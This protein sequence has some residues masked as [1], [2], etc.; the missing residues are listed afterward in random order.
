MWHYGSV[1]ILITLHLGVPNSMWYSRSTLF[2]MSSISYASFVL[3]WIRSTSSINIS[4]SPFS[5]VIPFSLYSSFSV[6]S[7]IRLQII[8]LIILPFVVCYLWCLFLSL[9]DV[10]SGSPIEA[11]LL[12]LCF[13]LPVF[14]CICIFDACCVSFL[15]VSF[16]LL[17]SCDFRLL[18][19]VFL[20]CC[21]LPWFHLSYTVRF[22]KNF[23]YSFLIYFFADWCLIFCPLFLFLF[24]SC[25]YCPV[26]PVGIVFCHFRCVT[27][28]LAQLSNFLLF[29]FLSSL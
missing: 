15:V 8:L 7:S 26:V 1:P 11:V 24:F 28:L 16:Q 10:W 14:L 6:I 20:G 5:I 18:T 21:F 2:V 25:S 13:G 9:A 12:L 23:P 22:F 29:V 3:S 19:L 17:I 4:F 27:I